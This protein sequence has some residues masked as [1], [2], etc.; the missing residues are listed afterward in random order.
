MKL[1]ISVDNS[2]FFM[3]AFVHAATPK[4]LAKLEEFRKKCILTSL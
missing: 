1:T 3:N 2:Y 4:N